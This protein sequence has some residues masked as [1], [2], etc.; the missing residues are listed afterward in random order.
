M[1]L[2]EIVKQITSVNA[3]V[4]NSEHDQ[5]LIELKEIQNQIT[6]IIQSLN[7]T[8][9]QTANELLMNVYSIK[10]RLFMFL[11]KFDHGL[12]IIEEGERQF[13]SM[14][15]DN[16]SVKRHVADLLRI[17]G[18]IYALKSEYDTA[19]QYSKNSLK[20]SEEIG[21]E[22]GIAYSLHNIG[23]FKSLIGDLDTAE[24]YLHRSLKLTKNINRG[25]GIPSSLQHLIELLI[26]K[27]ERERAKPYLD[28][29]RLINEAS[30]NRIHDLFY[31][32]SLALYLKSSNRNRNKV[33]AERL[34]EK[35]IIKND[36]LF[37][38]KIK[39]I[40]HLLELLINEFTLYHD[41][42]VFSEITSHIDDLYNIGQ[43]KE[44]YATTVEALIMKSKLQNIQGEFKSAKIFLDEAKLLAEEKGLKLLVQ[45]T[46]GEQKAMTDT[47]KNMRKMIANNRGLVERMEALELDDYIKKVQTLIG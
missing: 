25:K 6:P 37:E 12:S 27:N 29:L 42:E 44:M 22:R 39:C 10:S 16:T 34:F 7:K 19:L 28:Q 4:D 30:D 41:M 40:K 3:L 20:F 15:V 33:D 17:K 5:A 35:L 21:Y 8:E 9:K 43:T 36:F 24:D 18:A 32:Y 31:Q 47:I 23:V 11:G 1:T 13:E 46:E 2:D 14:D 45:K 38:V 26:K